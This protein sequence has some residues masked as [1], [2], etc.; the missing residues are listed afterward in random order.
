MEEIQEGGTV[1]PGETDLELIRSRIRE[2]PD[3]PKKGIAFKDITPL[4]QDGHAFRKAVDAMAAPFEERD[5][6]TICSAEARGF[7]FGAA[8]SYRLGIGF[9]PV[10]KPGKLPPRTHTVS[11]S[12]EYGTDSLEI[13]QDALAKGEKVLLVDDVLATGG[14]MEACC[15]L[16]ETAGGVVV[17]CLFLIELAA[18]GGREKLP[19]REIVSVLTYD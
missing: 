3:F 16:V 8:L 19:G 17:A 5:L 6:E 14:T 7:I 10:R 1:V 12:L 11:Y 15:R 2:V 18:L 4:L 13:R 9:A